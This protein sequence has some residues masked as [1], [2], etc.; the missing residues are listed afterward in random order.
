MKCIYFQL[1]GSILG[2][3][4]PT[5]TKTV[6]SLKPTNADDKS[7]LEQISVID[8]LTELIQS[9]T[10]D[11][12]P[13]FI[14]IYLTVGQGVTIDSTKALDEAVGKLSQTAGEVYNDGAVVAVVTVVNDVVARTKR[15]ASV[16]SDP[17]ST[18]KL[19]KKYL[20]QFVSSL[21]ATRS[22]QFTQP[23]PIILG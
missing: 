2:D 23:C 4:K 16:K 6:S 7:L 11:K 20:T 10:A 14:T 9:F 21:T 3:I 15:Q 8:Q 13:K 5:L 19:K 22:N 17:V 18:M 12:R 1:A